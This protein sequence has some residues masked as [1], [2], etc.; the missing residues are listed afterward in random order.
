MRNTLQD[1]VNEYANIYEQLYKSLKWKVSDTRTLMLVASMY[2]VNQKPFD[3]QRFEEISNGIKKDVGMFS[4]LNSPHRFT[5][6]AMLDIRFENPMDNFIE[7][8][9]IYDQLIDSKFSRETFTY[10]CAYLFLADDTIGDLQARIKRS[11]TFYKGMKSNHFFLTSSSDYPL[12]VLL[13]KEEG[14]VD[15]LLEKMEYFYEN[16]AQNGFSKGNDLQ[17][18]S[19]I[20]SLHSSDKTIVTERCTILLDEFKRRGD[21]KLRKM[22]Y[23]VLGL[24][25]FLEN[26]V[27]ELDRIK[28]INTLLNQNKR[29]KWNKDINLILAINFLMSEKIDNSSLIGTNMYTIIESIIQAQQAVMVATV[30]STAVASSSSGGE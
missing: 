22:H 16:L 26:G 2:V 28:E 24:L 1:K 9:K 8:L 6:A 18:L 11:M 14:S 29:F 30:T 23:P 21:I 19:H 7:L 17:F 15:E 13:A 5:Y 4:T 12:A 25:S 20:L 3:L 10:L 27:Q